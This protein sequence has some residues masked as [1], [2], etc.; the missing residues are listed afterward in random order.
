MKLK[1]I[2]RPLPVEYQHSANRGATGADLTVEKHLYFSA[3]RRAS[4]RC[5][6]GARSRKEC[7]RENNAGWVLTFVRTTAVV[8]NVDLKTP[9][10]VPAQAGTQWLLLWLD[11]RR[12]TLGPDFRQDDGGGRENVNLKTPSVVPAQAGTQWLL[13]WPD[14]R[15]KTLGPDFRQDDGGSMENVDLKTPSVVPAQ[16]GTQWLLL[17]LEDRRKTLG[18]DLR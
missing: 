15:G 1:F 14:D 18:P 12:K 10:V 17:W 13:S 6:P 16:A 5:R 9:P 8:E 2:S 4:R 3:V 11:D 7:G